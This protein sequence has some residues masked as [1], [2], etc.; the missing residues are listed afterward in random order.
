MI[1]R[2]VTIRDAQ[3]LLAIY[4]PYVEKTAITFEYTVPSTQEF[5]GRIQQ[6]I[7]KFPYL[8]AEADGNILGYA[9]A[10]VFK[11]RAA[12]D[13]AVET[14]LYVG[15]EQRGK[16]IGKA[17]YTAL[18]NELIARHI[19]NACACISYTDEE[20]AFLTNASMRFH[21]KMGY[22]LCGRFHQCGYKFGR[23]YDMIW[24]EKMLGAHRVDPQPVLWERKESPV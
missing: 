18:E 12:Y 7:K 23:W 17:L 2:P 1:I 9:Y 10:G 13:W 14:T 15:M 11:A 5:E 24:M 4:A 22:T 16:G 20:D 3:A 21:R 19:L 6:T 8:A